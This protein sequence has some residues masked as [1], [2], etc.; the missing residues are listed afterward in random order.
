MNTELESREFFPL[1]P[2]RECGGCTACC[3]IL[4]IDSLKLKKPADTPCPNCTKPGCRIYDTRPV[5]CRQYYCL[6]RHRDALSSDMRPEKLKVM[7]SVHYSLKPGDIL[8]KAF[9]VAS[10][11]EGWEIFSTP[12]VKTALNS[13]IED[14]ELPLWI[15]FRGQGKLVYPSPDLAQEIQHPGSAK[16]TEVA[17]EARSWLTRYEERASQLILEARKFAVVPVISK[18]AMPVSRLEAC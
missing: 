16:S 11:L 3:E 8:Q 4:S 7:F 15:N 17:L 10:T 6:W 9:I 18:T 13:L 14:L 5:V 1:I 2:E 12:E